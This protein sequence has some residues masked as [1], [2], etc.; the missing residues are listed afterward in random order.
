M[1][2]HLLRGVPCITLT[3]VL[4]YLHSQSVAKSSCYQFWQQNTFFCLLLLQYIFLFENLR[5]WLKYSYGH[6][7][8]SEPVTVVDVIHAVLMCSAYHP[9]LS[10]LVVLWF[11]PAGIQRSHSSHPLQVG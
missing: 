4:R 5:R 1:I 2:L 11:S 7:L 9:S 3:V 6:G 8:I 10:I